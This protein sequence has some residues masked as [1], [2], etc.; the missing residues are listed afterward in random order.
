M[1]GA[2][3]TAGAE[4]KNRA[5]RKP[6]AQGCSN[7]AVADDVPSRDS[8]LGRTQRRAAPNIATAAMRMTACNNSP[9]KGWWTYRAMEADRL[10]AISLT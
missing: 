9:L 4:A 10:A 5:T 2:V 6:A 7:T 3:D 8:A 1:M